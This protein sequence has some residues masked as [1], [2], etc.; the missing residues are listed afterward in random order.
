MKQEKR[1]RFIG[2]W[3]VLSWH[4]IL[5]TL[6][7]TTFKNL[8]PER[9]IFWIQIQINLNGSQDGGVFSN[10][11]VDDQKMALLKKHKKPNESR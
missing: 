5:L 1:Y 9:L 11:F 2:A 4:L 10:T 3:H 7:T 8:M 6:K